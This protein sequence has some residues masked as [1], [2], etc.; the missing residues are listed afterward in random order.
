M[1]HSETIGFVIPKN[2][3]FQIDFFP[4]LFPSPTPKQWEV[5]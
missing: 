1:V 5:T 3:F 2:R 4:N